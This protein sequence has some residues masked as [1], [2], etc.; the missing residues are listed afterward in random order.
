MPP[1]KEKLS[2]RDMIDLIAWL[3]TKWPKEI[4]QRW[5]QMDDRAQA[6]R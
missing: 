1:W 5:Q 4:Y 2:E 3:Q 6:R